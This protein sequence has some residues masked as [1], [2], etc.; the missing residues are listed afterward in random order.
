MVFRVRAAGEALHDADDL[1]AQLI[2][3]ERRLEA[4]RVEQE[5]VAPPGP[6]FLLRRAQEALP[7][8]LSPRVLADPERLD[9]AG[10]APRA[11]V[12][13]GRDPDRVVADEDGQPTAA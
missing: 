12:K 11:P 2:V 9:P 4:E 1:V 6:G 8:A 5:L 10:P 13:A 3:K 7:V